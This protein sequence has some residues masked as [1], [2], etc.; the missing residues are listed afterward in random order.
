MLSKSANELTIGESVIGYVRVTNV[1]SFWNSGSFTSGPAFDGVAALLERERWLYEQ[2]ENLPL[3]ASEEQ[4]CA[5]HRAWLAAIEAINDL[6]I[7]LAGC[8]VRDF[9]VDLRGRC[10]FKID[11]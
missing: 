2:Y 7:C 8:R 1:D 3:D 6:N 11:R 5:A 10:E 4:S 9:K